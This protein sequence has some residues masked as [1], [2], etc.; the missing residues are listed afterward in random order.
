MFCKTIQEDRVGDNKVG[1]NNWIDPHS[2]MGAHCVV[3]C[4][5]DQD[6]LTADATQGKCST[7][8]FCEPKNKNFGVSGARDS[9]SLWFKPMEWKLRNVKV[10]EL[11]PID[12]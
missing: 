10:F 8:G 5:K 9:D 4:E 3:Q 1:V 12:S 11:D 6:C 2:S 7:D